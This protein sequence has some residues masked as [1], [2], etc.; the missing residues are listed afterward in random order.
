MANLLR[1]GLPLS[2]SVM[3]IRLQSSVFLLWNVQKAS[4]GF[5]G[6]INSEFA[7]FLLHIP[8]EET[9]QPVR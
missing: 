6:A 2:G 4:L 1:G 3:Q 7:K 8:T 9:L 5:G